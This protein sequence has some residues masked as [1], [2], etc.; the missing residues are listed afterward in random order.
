MRY[1]FTVAVSL[2]GLLHVAPACSGDNA[3]G[4]TG[5][6]TTDANFLLPDSAS[7]GGS[8]LGGAGGAG[9]GSG[10]TAMDAGGTAGADAS[11]DA[12]ID[13]AGDATGG[14]AGDATT[15]SPAD[16]AADTSIQDATGDGA[17]DASGEAS[18]DA[19]GCPPSTWRCNGDA[20][21]QCAIDG[22]GYALVKTC[23]AG[24]CHAASGVCLECS[25]PGQ[26]PSP[27]EC[28][29]TTCAS[30]ICGTTPVGAGLACSTGVC[31]GVGGCGVCLPGSSRC[32]GST[33]EVCSA[34]GSWQTDQVCP[35]VCSSGSCVGVCVPGSK[36]CSGAT[37]QVCSTG[38]NWQASEVCAGSTP[39]CQEGYCQ[40]QP[41]S[42]AGLAA[43]CGASATSG[44]CFTRQVPAQSF[45]RSYD[46]VLYTDPS[47]D[48]QVSALWVDSYEVT[49]GRFRKFVQAG[50]GTSASPPAPGAGAHPKLSGSGWQASW[51]G[52]LAANTAAL[53]SS[54]ACN[55]LSTWTAT[56]STNETRPINCV[57]WYEAFAFCAWDGGRLPTEAEWN[58]TA[59]GGSEQRVYPWSAPPT[60]TTLGSTNASYWVDATNT[61]MGDGT[62]GCTVSD[63]IF[64]GSKPAG[65]GRWG[66]FELAGNV[67]EWTLDAF[68]NPYAT[69]PCNDCAS[70]SG[71]TKAIRGGSFF[72]QLAQL[73]TSS[74]AFGDGAQRFFTVGLRC[75]R[76]L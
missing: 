51:N 54:L 68:T 60:N 46:A 67:A 15:D 36:G 9:A 33:R 2:L 17:P 76:D 44:C 22:S 26:C 72:G 38:G 3:G 35:F 4:G 45:K 73:P 6:V 65:V 12:L 42:C 75:A 58:L 62:P 10:G 8:G 34:T 20:L 69:N 40:P 41:P 53:E 70:L 13:A 50:H 49:V 37:A 32:A 30:G 29:Q 18:T 16:A 14:A 5:G 24:L 27:P 47:F 52:E 19:A 31:N 25:N 28:L 56:P 55:A 7:S 61:C 57:S 74:R 21:E 39:A 66:H 1:Q 59:S 23:K 11:A 43:T 71:S 48:A 63:L 64:A